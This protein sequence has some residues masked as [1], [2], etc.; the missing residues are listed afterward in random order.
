MLEKQGKYNDLSPKLREDLAKAADKA[1]RYVKYRF[2]IARKNPDGEHRTGGEY[3]YPL[4]Y[5]LTPVTFDIIDP[6]DKQRK[7]IGI[8]VALKE[9]GANSDD[10]A[11]IE[12][13]EGWQGIYTLDMEK[14]DDMDKFAYLELHPKLEGGLLR[15]PNSPAMVAR[16]DDKQRATDAIRLRNVKIDAMFAASNM[17]HEEVKDFASAMGWDEALDIMILKDQIAELAERDPNFFIDFINDK[18]LEHKAVIK[19][20][21]D[22]G[23]LSWVPVE[24]KFIWNSNKQTIAVLERMQGGKELERMSEWIFTSKNG[25]EVYKRIKAMLQERKPVS[26]G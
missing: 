22:N 8:V 24:N 20:A 2:A 11:R 14:P 16:V 13:R 10:F 4:L 12:I 6:Y 26:V 5:T 19:R 9:N 3:I 23:I 18:G 25:E 21:V 15:D 1:G 7:K 17:N